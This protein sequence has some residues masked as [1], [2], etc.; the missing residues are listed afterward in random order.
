LKESLFK[1]LA[2]CDAKATQPGGFFLPINRGGLTMSI[3]AQRERRN[4]AAI[5]ARTLVDSRKNE[6]WS[7]SDQSRYEEL[8]S[9]IVDLDSAIA[10]EQ[11]LL[12]IEA[13]RHFNKHDVKVHDKAPDLLS[14]RGIVNSWLRNGERGL[15]AEQ[16]DRFMNTMS[17]TTGSEGGYSVRSD[18]ASDFIDKLKDYSGLRQV[19]TVIRTAQGNALSYPTTDGTSE[20]GELIAENTTATDADIS[21]G[22]VPLTAYKFSSKIVTV[23]IE[24]LM[25][26]EIDVEA[27]V[28]A[29]FAA[30]IGR[31]QNS[32]FTT[33]TGSS[34]PKGVITAASTGKTGASGQTTTIIFEDLVDL[35][36]SIDQAYLDSGECKF[37]TSQTMRGTLRKLKDSEGRPLWLPGYDLGLSGG[38]SDMLMGHK[39]Q[40]NN[41]VAVPAA[42]AKSLAFGDFSKYIIRDV[43]DVSLFRFTDSA[44]TKKGQVGFLAWARSGGNL[45]DTAAVKL[46]VHAAS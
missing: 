27:L 38:L 21:F 43:M 8:T 20:T 19:A 30:R 35:I 42:S 40:I 26:S 2:A 23:P 15:N 32:Y 7:D 5:E 13:D 12:D 17:T 44:Y 46:Y 37:M 45:V 24:L 11:Q 29:R 28:R 25:D 16:M 6:K 18:V 22:T 10:R 1:A 9:T 36:E 31:I 14:E 34:E 33:G 3:Q 39:V 4:A 41:S